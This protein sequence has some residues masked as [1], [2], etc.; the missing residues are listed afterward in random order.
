MIT[1]HCLGVKK[2]SYDIQKTEKTHINTE[3]HISIQINTARKS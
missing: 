1:L 3:K 2:N